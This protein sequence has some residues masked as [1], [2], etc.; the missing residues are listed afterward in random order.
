MVELARSRVRGPVL[1]GALPNLPL[2]DNLFDAVTANFVVNHVS[3]PAASVRDLA[4]VTRP[5]GSV[6]M[7]I[8]PSPTTTPG[9]WREFIGGIYADAGVR[10]IPSGDLDPSL[11]FERSAVGLGDLA[12]RAGLETLACTDLQW[13][14]TIAPRDLWAGI[15]GGVAGAGAT[16][17]AQ[18]PDTRQRVHN[19]FTTRAA[20]AV[21]PAGALTFRA[22]AAYVLA[23]AT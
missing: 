20:E 15:A 16:Y 18:T 23:L 2:P 17:L 4:R 19:L 6:A 8:W 3:N 21:G 11:D 7:T 12:E 5:G 1:Q 22:T 13:E 10:P 9:G 14:W